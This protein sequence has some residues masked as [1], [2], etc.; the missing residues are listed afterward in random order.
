MVKKQKEV[1]VAE[2][3]CQFRNKVWVADLVDKLSSSCN[4][5]Q[6]A[7]EG[8]SSIIPLFNERVIFRVA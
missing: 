3:A 6:Q 8:G 1:T 2:A 7:L 5:N 4:S